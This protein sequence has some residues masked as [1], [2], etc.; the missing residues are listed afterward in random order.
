MKNKA[1]ETYSN[2]VM[3]KF[4]EDS[5]S[6]LS[7]YA[8]LYERDAPYLD[9]DHPETDMEFLERCIELDFGD[10]YEALAFLEAFV[11]VDDFD[12]QFSQDVSN[13]MTI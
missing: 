11:D 6:I 2:F 5:D 7:T 4:N 10:G 1:F 9:R 8:D 3:N 12:E 13:S